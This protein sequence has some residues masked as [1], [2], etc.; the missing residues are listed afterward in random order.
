M[1]LGRKGN[2]EK[3]FHFF[4]FLTYYLNFLS[5]A[6]SNHIIILIQIFSLYVEYLSSKFCYL[7]ILIFATFSFPRFLSIAGEGL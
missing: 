6:Y 4:I 5:P 1:G 2:E 3:D 7:G